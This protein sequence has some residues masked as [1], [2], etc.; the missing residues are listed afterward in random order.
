MAIFE[1][2]SK[3]VKDLCLRSGDI[4]QRSKGLYLNCAL[5]VYKDMEITSLKIPKRAIFKINK[6]TN[7]VDLPC[8]ALQLSGVNVMDYNGVFYPVFKN[9][10]LHN[11]MIDISAAKDC[12]CEEKCGYQLCN[13]IK[14]YEAI[15]ETTSEEMP[16]GSFQDF[17]STTKKGVLGEIFYIEK[18][19]P[20]RIYEDG[21]WTDVQ[22]TTEKKELCKVEINANGCVCDTQQNIDNL[23]AC[24]GLEDDSAVN[25]QPRICVGGNAQACGTATEWVYYCGSK[26]DWFSVECGVYFSTRRPFNNIYNINEAGNRLIFPRDFGFDKVMI[27]WY[28]D[29]NLNEMQ[30]PFMAKQT[31]MKGLQYYAAINNEKKQNL[32]LLYSRDYTA[33]KFGLLLELNKYRIAEWRMILTPPV[34]MPSYS[35]IAN[36]YYANGY[37]QDGYYY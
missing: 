6:R 18:T 36:Q 10:R 15:Q 8:N 2:V 31:F 14:G 33:M 24:C 3:V 37:Y 11:D 19:Y 28:T 5:D 30:I 4:L 9:D 13:M 32:A 16:D 12:A 34:Y 1:P 23:C 25:N 35:P 17:T 7:T 26:M 27:R 22:L 20:Q 29:I 21:V